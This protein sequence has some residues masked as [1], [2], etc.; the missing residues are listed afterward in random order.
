MISAKTAREIAENRTNRYLGQIEQKI[1]DAASGGKTQVKFSRELPYDETI[2]K[3]LHD[4]GYKT[5]FYCDGV[6]WELTIDW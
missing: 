1:K 2:E 6:Y 3:I 5:K 4:A